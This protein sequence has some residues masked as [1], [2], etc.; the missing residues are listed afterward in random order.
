MKNL[1][2][3]KI[4]IILSLLMLQACASVNTFPTLARAGSTV[5]VLVGGS[6]DARKET[7]AV[8]LT[9]INGG[10]WDLK[11]M[12]LVRSLFNVQMDN[13]S[14]GKNYSSFLDTFTP[15]SYGHEQLQSV[16][17]TDLPP[18]LPVGAAKIEINTNISRLR[19]ALTLGNEL[20]VN[21]TYNS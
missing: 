21:F 15:W 20:I 18:S 5:S 7:T 9:D 4:I 16:L 6:D 10:I 11:A 12:G 17:I 1:Q 13:K 8:T 3:Y 14:V 19:Q 2:T